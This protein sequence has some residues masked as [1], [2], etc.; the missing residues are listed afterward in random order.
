MINSLQ[1][2][3]YW[4][5]TWGYYD[6]MVNPQF[7]PLDH[8]PCYKPKFWE[9]PDADLQLMSVDNTTA[10]PAFQEY[11]L[12]IVPGSL[13]VGFDNDDNAPIFQVQITDVSTQLKFWDSPI[14]NYFLTNNFNEYPSLLCSPRPVVGTG[15][16]KVELWI[17]PNQRAGQQIRCGFTM[18]GAEPVEDCR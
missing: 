2:W 10:A 7:A 16:F 8:N 1:L 11:T 5:D 3:P 12:R 18:F 13:I 14:S 17:D 6:A 15:V 4:R 9:V